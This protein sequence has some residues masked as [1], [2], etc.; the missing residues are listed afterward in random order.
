[1]LLSVCAGVAWCVT[2]GPTGEQRR[3]EEEKH[4]GWEA[5]FAWVASLLHGSSS[6]ALTDAWAR[7]S[8]LRPDL[9]KALPS[10]I[11]TSAGVATTRPTLSSHRRG[12]EGNLGN[13]GELAMDW[14]SKL[15]CSTAA[16]L[17]P[18]MLL[19]VCFVC[20]RHQ[21]RIREP[22]FQR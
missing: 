5:A 18:Y 22:A 19:S 7:F 20:D 12:A 3:E 1:M 2:P 4:T 8:P 21:W 11:I 15:G 17:F 16:G 14:S 6:A 10:V 13:T 9:N